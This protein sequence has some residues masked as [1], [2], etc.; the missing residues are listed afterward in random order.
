MKTKK[1]LYMLLTTLMIFSSL[2]VFANAATAGTLALVDGN[3]G[4]NEVYVAV[5]SETSTAPSWPN[6][7]VRVEVTNVT[8][9]VGAV[10]S[11][12]WNSTLFAMGSGN[13]TYGDYLLPTGGGTTQQL[14]HVS[15]GEMG[16]LVEIQLS[17]QSPKTF[18]DP[19]WGWVATLTFLYIGPTPAY[20][21]SIT[22]QITLVDDGASTAATEW[23]TDGTSWNKFEA[24]VQ[25]DF[26]YEYPPLPPS[27]PTA[28]FT[29]SPSPPFYEEDTITFDASASQPGFDGDEFVPI[30]AYVW[31][32]GDGTNA[33]TASPV[34]AHTFN[35]SGLYPVCLITVAP[36]D[37]QGGSGYIDPGYV[38]TS[39]LICQDVRIN[40]RSLTGID[41][42][43]EDYR[44]PCYT[45]SYIG[46]GVNSTEPVD[47]FLPQEK[48]TIC[49]YVFYNG[50]P[51]QNKPVAF[52][53][54]GPKNPFQNITVYRTA[55]TSGEWD[56]F[57]YGDG[58]V[59]VS[60]R[61]PWPCN[62]SEAI[63]FGN[64]TVK[65]SVVLPLPQCQEEACYEDILMFKVGWMV[66][67]LDVTVHRTTSRGSYRD[68]MEGYK[69]CAIVGIRATVHNNYNE[70]RMAFLTAVMYDDV[71]TPIATVSKWA[72]IEP[73]D[74]T[75]DLGTVHIPKWAYSGLYPVVYANAY[76]VC[77]DESGILAPWGPEVASDTFGIAAIE[78]SE[79]AAAYPWGDNDDEFLD[80]CVIYEV[81]NT[82]SNS[83]TTVSKRGAGM[84]YSKW[85]WFAEM[86]AVLDDH[87]VDV[88]DIR[89]ALIGYIVDREGVAESVALSWI[90]AAEAI[91]GFACP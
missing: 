50:D 63:V 3:D 1:L 64:W 35:D 9:I 16:E 68:I 21:T 25:L 84:A 73:G 34:I 12:R 42:F 80:H 2:I 74:P 56:N 69:K 17:P 19:T 27:P 60:F 10:L 71:G 62:N 7:D 44:W 88:E 75:V 28:S 82:V 53:I 22:S 59:C 40:V 31:D 55:F 78:Y 11:V 91:C 49:A 89:E 47:G 36:G 5:G 41:V 15:A 18:A 81:I 4:D 83:S 33:S 14:D 24:F 48:V 58:Y 26:E 66:Q 20:G 57:T 8:D 72:E 79:C 76:Y 6:F 30:T 46:L 29:I 61:I 86:Y 23:T 38:N 85:V 54:E 13:I 51:V 87:V 67:V 32:F 43:T 52:V 39:S 65:A 45:T 90:L 70:P 77:C 37:D